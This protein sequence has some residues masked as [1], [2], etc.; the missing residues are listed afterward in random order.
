MLQ[1]YSKAMAFPPVN[2]PLITT[3]SPL[4]QGFQGVPYSQQLTEAGGVAPYT[5]ALIG[6]SLDSGLSLSASG[7]IAGTPA[8]A[9]TDSFIVRITDAHGLSSQ[10]HFNLTVAPS[11]LTFLTSSPLPTATPTV[12]YSFSS[13]QAAGGVSPYAFSLLAETGP[14]TWA[15]SSAGVVTGTPLANN[16]LLLGTETGLI[17]IT[18]TGLLLVRDTS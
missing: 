14:D 4:P 5:Y 10:T 9:E 17:F 2:L 7:L 6:G 18:E 1:F 12:P 15:V 8:N 3:P 11:T 13:I 16:P